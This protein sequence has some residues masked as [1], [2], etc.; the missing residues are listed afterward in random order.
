[1]ADAEKFEY[2][3][4]YDNLDKCNGNITAKVFREAA[5]S[6]LEELQISSKILDEKTKFKLLLRGV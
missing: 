4:N 6:N 3:Y 2:M 1:M 5:F